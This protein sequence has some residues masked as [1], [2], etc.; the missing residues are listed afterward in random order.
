ME[1]LIGTIIKGYE[2]VELIGTGGFGAVFRAKQAVVGREV[3]VKVILP[4]HASAPMFIRRFETEAQLV[5][6]LEHPYIVPLYDYWRD[7]QGAYLVM[8]YLR[9]GSLTDLIKERGSLSLEQAGRMLNQ[10]ASALAVAHQNGVVHRD[11]KPD[12][13]LIDETNNYYLSDFGIAK[14]LGQSADTNLT[15]TGTIIG[16]P[17]YLSPEQIKGDPITNLSDVYS[18]GILLHYTLTGEH[19]YPGKTP[20]AMLVHQMQDPMPRLNLKLDNVPDELEE[21]LQRATAKDP[22]MRYQS[23]MELAMSYNRALRPPGVTTSQVRRVNVTEG[24]FIVTAADP[25]NLQNPYKGLKAFEE[26][27]ASDFFGRETLVEDLVQRLSPK[28]DLEDGDHLLVVIGPSGSGKSSVVKAGL[29]PALRRGDVPD[30]ENWFFV[31]MVPSLHP[32]EEME[33]ALLRVAVNPPESLLKQL[34]ED[35]RGLVRALKRVLPDD[36]SHLFLFIDQFEEVFTLTESEQER[37]HFL[38][39]LLMAVTEPRNRLRLV[40]TLRADFYDRPLSYHAFGELVRTYTEVVLPLSPQELERA[41]VQPAR[42]IGMTL[43]AG[44]ASAIVSDVRDQPGAL[45]LMQYA[46]SELFEH[47]DGSRLT[48]NAYNQIGGAMGALA[49]RAET[50]F[51]E[52]GMEAKDAARQLFLRLVTLGEGAEDTRRR[53]NRSELNTLEDATLIDEIILAF[54]KQRLLTFD[55]DPQTRE[56]TVEVAHEALIREWR[57]LR[58]W[59]DG[60]REELRTHRRLFNAASEWENSGR[61]TSFLATG[62]RLDQFETLQQSR[63]IAMNEIEATYMAQSLQRRVEREQ[64]EA[65]RIAREEALEEAARNRLRALLTVVSVAA[66]VAIALAVF[67]FFARRDAI[68]AQGEAEVAAEIANENQQQ[69]QAVALSA[70]ALNLID[71]HNPTLALKLVREAVGL[72]GDV[73]AVQRALAEVAYAP[74]AVAQLNPLEGH[75]AVAMAFQ[76]DGA[77]IA[78]GMSNGDVLLIDTATREVVNQWTAHTGEGDAPTA[79][80]AIAEN[81]RGTILATADGQGL[82]RLWDINSGE[83]IAEYTEHSARVT[84]LHFMPDGVNLLSAAMDARMLLWDINSGEVVR[85]YVGHV[86]GVLSADVTRDGERIVS[87]TADDP[88]DSANIDRAVRVW[89]VGSNEPLLSLRASGSGWLRAAAISNDGN[90]AAVASYD[91]NEYG[92][93]IRL[94]NLQTQQVERGFYGHSDVITTLDFS[95]DGQTLLSGSWDKSIRRWDVDTGAELQRFDVHSDR[96]L[97]VVFSPDGRQAITSSGRDSGTAPDNSVL[98]LDLEN[99]GEVGVLRGHRNWVWGVA[100]SPD[101]A[102]IATGSGDLNV[103]AGDNSIR[104]WDA[105]TMQQVARLV[106]H[107]DTVAGVAFN[108]ASDTLASGSWDGTVRLWNLDDYTEAAQLTGHEGAVNDVDFSPDGSIVLSASS[109]GTLRLWNLSNGE[110]IRTI[111]G[112]HEGRVLRAKFNP[113]GDLVASAG[114]DSM[115]RLWNVRTGELV[116]EYTGHSGWVSTVNFSHDGRFIVSGADDDLILWDTTVEAEMGEDDDIDPAEY[117]RL[118]GHQGFVYGGV[119]SPDDKYIMSGA[120]DVTVRLWEV[121]TTQE[122]RRFSGHTNWILDIKFSPDGTTAVTGAEDNT[123]RIW[124]IARS[125]EELLEWAEDNRYI[126]ELTCPERARYNVPPYCEGFEP[127]DSRAREGRSASA[128]D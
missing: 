100:Y 94:W 116:R 28:S 104:L 86:G 54:G 72:R 119:F 40:L 65:D 8:R 14:D 117:D 42:Q 41:V 92:G 106:G 105:T 88:A 15:Q 32:M 125:T 48:L 34:T 1:H 102:L 99:Q 7:P 44:L 58:E 9:G 69:S 51:Q 3:A 89:D 61:E 68:V 103:S 6:R 80:T 107:E 84:T 67:A 121:A 126:P 74:A 95:P 110:L 73:T 112:A 13:I 47:R 31:E 87:S 63:S 35:E 21:V 17:A 79:V 26:A 111:T 49:Q 11:L 53:V 22:D 43:E 57:R 23:V 124:R 83:M 37:Q 70:S 36:G 76:S 46:L 113:N 108:P 50:I 97:D 52:L 71:N 91:P 59:L 24:G 77:L 96:M 93:T 62:A 38:N 85:E 25:E 81:V 115:V 10:I 114:T 30:S 5:A 90:Y 18:L 123:A 101:G 66:V 127:N 78:M 56:P 39:S 27:D 60:A 75:S 12:N 118:V 82:I 109:D 120:S 4:E 20:T 45:P 128:D 16:S 55:N 2:L 19:P 33:A 98:L 29:I 122:I 64:A